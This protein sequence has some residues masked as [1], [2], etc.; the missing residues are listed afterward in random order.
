[1]QLR[2][3]VLVDVVAG[4][5]IPAAIRAARRSVRAAL[6][7]GRLQVEKFGPAHN[8]ALVQ[9][10]E[11]PE[12]VVRVAVAT[13]Q[14]VVE[15]PTQLLQLAGVLRHHGRLVQQPAGLARPVQIVH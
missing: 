10:H 7:F 15:G 6:N 1:V 9:L 3:N 5:S 2:V 14:D 11:L 13:V 8:L 12:G 4:R